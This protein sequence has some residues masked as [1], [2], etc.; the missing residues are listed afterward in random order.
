MFHLD[1][2]AVAGLPDPGS[3][4]AGIRDKIDPNFK[5]LVFALAGVLALRSLLG[6]R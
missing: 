2:I 5:T 3:F 4:I 6:L 1:L